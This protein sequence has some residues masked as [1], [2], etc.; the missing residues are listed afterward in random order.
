MPGVAAAEEEFSA[1]LKAN[2][3]VS[4]IQFSIL[5]F[6]ALVQNNGYSGVKELVE[7]L[8]ELFVEATKSI[9]AERP[10]FLGHCGG[11][12]FVVLCAE[13]SAESLAE[14][15]RKT[16]TAHLSSSGDRLVS[17]AGIAPVSGAKS[18]DEVAARLASVVAEVARVGKSSQK[19][20]AGS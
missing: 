2:K 20:W 3:E 14:E 4:V 6:D 7:D 11:A 16:V 1:A 15:I 10:Y 9:L 5:G 8:G 18:T 19:N 17:I 12:D 13:S